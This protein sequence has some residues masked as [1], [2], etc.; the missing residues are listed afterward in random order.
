MNVRP[1][2]WVALLCAGA[3][4]SYWSM[5]R[6]PGTSYSGALP[7][8]T[9]EQQALQTALVEHVH[10]LATT[11]G[12]RNVFRP[13]ALA[14]AANYIEQA[15]TAAGYTVERQAYDVGDIICANLIVEIPGRTRPGE[16]VVVGAHYDTVRGSPGA[17]DNASGMAAVL[18]LARRWHGTKPD[19]TLRFVAFVNEEPPFFRTPRMGSVVYARRC[20]ER[21]ENIVAMLTPETIGYYSDERGSQRYPPPF[22]LFYPNRG[23]FIAVVGNWRSR[24]LVRRAVRTF[25]HTTD[26]PS[27]GAAPPGWIPGVGWSDHWAFWQQGYPGIMFTDTAPFRYPHYHRA[28]DTADQIDYDRFTRVVSGIHHVIQDLVHSDQ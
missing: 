21:G 7:P 25:R 9:K 11:I 23:D 28:T 4:W 1:A 6:M 14:A 19:R 2:V 3:V 27:E 12:E 16:I 15:F 10:E 13:D 5:I 17:N 24:A 26:F 8:L 22:S 18:A 20:A